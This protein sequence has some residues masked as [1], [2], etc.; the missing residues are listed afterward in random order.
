[1]N[2]QQTTTIKLT[3][4]IPSYTQQH[5]AVYLG[6]CLEIIKSI[7]D[8][9]VN[10]ILT[11]PPFALT[12][13]K[14]YGNE[15]AEKYIE[16][17]LPFADEFKRV[18][19]ENGSF[20]LDLGGAYLPGNPV[21]SIYQYE[22]LVKLCKEVGFF[23]AQEFYHYNPARLPTPAEWVTIRRVR[24]KDAVNI[25]WWLSKTPNPKADNKKILKPYSQS[26]KRLLE[27][28]YKAQVRPSGHDISDKFQ[29]DNQGAI[30]PNL[31][32]IANTESNS[33]YLRRCKAAGVKPHP[34]RFP[35]GFAEF[36]IKF[37]TDEGDLV[38]D[39]FAGSNTTGFVAETWQRRW[40]A[41]EINQDYVLGS[42][43]RFS[44]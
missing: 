42:R 22:L 13:K 8:N 36:F 35:Q 39:P 19:T 21:R 4:F 34:A 11:S 32:E 7:P 38:L 16:W 14:E 30:P 27:K 17:F 18:L 28:G 12:R 44:E 29:K 40:I 2:S 26:M 24:V 33:T 41:V 23:L 43:Y 15:S 25:V 5:G 1:M 6:D 3:N 31:L 37:L 10:L 20:I 9:S